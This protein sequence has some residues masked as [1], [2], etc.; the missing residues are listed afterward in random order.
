MFLLWL[1]LNAITTCGRGKELSIIVQLGFYFRF[2]WSILL[3]LS[4]KLVPS[5]CYLKK[6]CSSA[7]APISFEPKRFMYVYIWV[8]SIRIYKFFIVQTPQSHI[9]DFFVL[10]LSSKRILMF[11]HFKSFLVYY[12]VAIRQILT[13]SI[14]SVYI[15]HVLLSTL[16]MWVQ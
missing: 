2:L 13:S 14:G 11:S 7:L 3:C 10:I 9:I 5:Y 6:T 15:C 1:C 16:F 4:K 8:Q 12:F